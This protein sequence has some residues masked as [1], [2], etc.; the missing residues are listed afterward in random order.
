M[1]HLY[2]AARNDGTLTIK[3]KKFTFSNWEQVTVGSNCTRTAH[4]LT[5]AVYHEG[6]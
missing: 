1:Y 5:S 6:N 3:E 4:T 2:S